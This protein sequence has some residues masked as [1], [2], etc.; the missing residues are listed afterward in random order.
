M[1]PLNRPTLQ[2]FFRSKVYQ[3]AISVVI[4]INAIVLGLECSSDIKADF[5]FTLN[6]IDNVCLAIFV[7]E[8]L[9]KI[10]AFRFA[11]FTGANKGWNIFDFIIVLLSL[12][13]SGGISVLRAL[14]IFRAMRLLSV[15]PQMR[16]VTEAML[17]TLPSLF[18]VA[19]CVNPAH[20]DSANPLNPLRKGGGFVLLRIAK[21][22][23]RTFLSHI[24]T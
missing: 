6:L 18:G 23:S 5:G 4:V 20:G 16:I 17:H 22:K 19:I 14:R 24:I 10:Y 13:A 3:I 11:F 2:H 15:L 12:C 8:L 21:N 9:L 7:V 1:N